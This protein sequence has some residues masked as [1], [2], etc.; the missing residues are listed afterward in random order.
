MTEAKLFAGSEALHWATEP[1]GPD[2][3]YGQYLSY[4][5]VIGPVS[6]LL[7]AMLKGSG[8]TPSRA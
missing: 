7:I 1:Y 4:L 8:R 6:W 5:L 2:G 3:K